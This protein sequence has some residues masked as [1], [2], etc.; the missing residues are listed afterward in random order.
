VKLCKNCKYL[1]REWN[2]WPIR[3]PLELSKC[4][5]HAKIDMASGELNANRMPFA[6]TSREWGPCGAEA[7]F[8]EPR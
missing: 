6:T 7:K 8:W 5:K 2:M 4:S 3:F 1:F